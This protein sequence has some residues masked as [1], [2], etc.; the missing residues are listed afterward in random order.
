MRVN[1]AHLRQQAQSGGWINFAVFEARSFSGS[2]SDNA[3]LLAQLTSQAQ[4][5][6]LK[7]DQSALAFRS[8]GRLQFFGTKPLVEFLS[9]SGLPRW[10]H[11]LDR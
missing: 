8:N 1:F 3:G 11:H 4:A 10:N 2:D 5:N 9:K 7:I 6:R